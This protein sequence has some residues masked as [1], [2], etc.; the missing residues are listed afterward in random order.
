MCKSKEQSNMTS[1]IDSIFI[2]LQSID[3]VRADVNTVQSLLR[4]AV[5]A[6]PQ[7]STSD[8]QRLL[9]IVLDSV[10][11]HWSTR[12]DDATL[13]DQLL[14]DAPNSALPLSAVLAAPAPVAAHWLERFVR[15]GAALRRVFMQLSTESATSLSVFVRALLGAPARLANGLQGRVPAKLRDQTFTAHVLWESLHTLVAQDAARTLVGALAAHAVA[16]GQADAVGEAF[17]RFLA[18]KKATGHV[19]T[20]RAALLAVP[21]HAQARVLFALLRVA[22]PAET[23]AVL[24]ERE[25]GQSLVL[26]SPAFEHFLSSV[27]LVGNR[28]LPSLAHVDVVVAHLVALNDRVDASSP[29][30]VARLADDVATVW[31]DE[32]FVSGSSPDAELY[33]SRVLLQ[34]LPH[35]TQAQLDTGGTLLT[36]L[37]DGVRHRLS[38]PLRHVRINGMRVGEAFSKIIDPTNPLVFD[39]L[40]EAAAAAAA[41]AAATQQPPAAA[42]VVDEP[43][44]PVRKAKVRPMLDPD[45]VIFDDDEDGDIA[46]VAVADAEAPIDSDDEFT[47]FDLHESDDDEDGVGGALVP[48]SSTA[49]AGSLSHL[50]DLMVGL[51]EQENAARFEAALSKLPGV[52]RGK[53]DD[54]DFEQTVVALSSQLLHLHN[55]FALESFT[56]NRFES[57]LEACCAAPAVVARYLTG[58]FYDVNLDMHQR[59]VVLEVLAESAQRLAGVTTP[60]PPPPPPI[61]APRKLIEVM[62]PSSASAR[63]LVDQ[64]VESQTR[65]WGDVRR[66]QA[67]QTSVS[68]FRDVAEIFFFDLMRRVDE[69]HVQLRL[70]TDSGDGLLL[71]RLI[72]CAS[73]VVECAGSHHP[74]IDRMAR[75]LLDFV[76]TVRFHRE[77][78]V[79]R[80]CA[81]AVVASV[82]TL[83]PH[84]RSTPTL[85]PLLVECRTWLEQCVANDVD[86]DV[87]S[88]AQIL[89]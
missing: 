56:E 86:P 2:E 25:H 71:G 12:L 50:G 28:P 38:S 65:R 9:A 70:L 83:P 84:L 33:V 14:F 78:F 47:A 29:L 11:L 68:A 19:N 31:G 62:S 7:L 77:P 79:R 46:A 59:I 73:I 49:G 54:I 60:S 18:V 66:R 88:L 30:H 55:R 34:F 23:A 43:D 44:S 37:V 72:Q 85:A 82:R 26:A 27:V 24:G 45:A 80:A 20:V 64:R 75:L 63:V 69:Q 17:H 3:H 15:D 74:L 10:W 76:L 21:E 13:F 4:R 22:S 52:L 36:R 32:A 16:I 67:P 51:R 40:K 58:A 35:V 89:Q 1:E 5:R 8:Q 57:L 42:V 48:L 87:R 53:P 61:E 81:Y 39:E 6:L 41:A